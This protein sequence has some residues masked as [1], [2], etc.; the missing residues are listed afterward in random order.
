MMN[1]IDPIG[2]KHAQSRPDQR[3]EQRFGEELAH[4]AESA[5]AHGGADSKLMLTGRAA[6]KEKNRDVAAADSEQQR[7]GPEEQVHRLLEIAG[8]GL[9]QT[10]HAD[11]ELLGEDI[12]RLLVE[13]LIEG[14]E[15]GSGSR[16]TD[17]GLQLDLRTVPMSLV[18]LHLQR[19]VDISIPPREAHRHHAEDRVA[20]MVELDGFPHN[21]GIAAVMPLPELVA[22]YR[23]GLGILAIGGI[24][25][26]NV[27]AQDGSSARGTGNA[28]PTSRSQPRRRVRHCQ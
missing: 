27:P 2:D 4:D 5:R 3:Q 24:G 7:D 23:Y 8:V 9:R 17:A 25:R 13:L 21:R 19:D 1:P 18:R 12:R 11:L 28:I 10:A 20:L 16:E 14:P 22:Q 6:R 15:F 26:H